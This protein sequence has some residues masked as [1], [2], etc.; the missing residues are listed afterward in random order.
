[1]AFDDLEESYFAFVKSVRREIPDPLL[2]AI[3]EIAPS[4]GER[5]IV[6]RGAMSSTFTGILSTVGTGAGSFGGSTSVPSAGALRRLRDK[7][8]M[9]STRRA[10]P[11]DEHANLPRKRSNLVWLGAIGA[12]AI[13]AAV[14]IVVMMR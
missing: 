7:T 10:E 9:R 14:A 8:G 4:G 11:T 2:D 12:A 3:E 5:K 13:I 1:M 6:T